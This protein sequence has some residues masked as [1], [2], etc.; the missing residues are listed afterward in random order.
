MATGCLGS[1]RVSF[2][3]VE[4]PHMSVLRS[5]VAAKSHVAQVG[6]CS[7]SAQGL[8]SETVGTWLIRWAFLFLCEAKVVVGILS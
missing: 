3:G 6:G 8:P 7:R 4:F 5:T 1:G 2:A